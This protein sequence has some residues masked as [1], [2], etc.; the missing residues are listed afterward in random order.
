MGYNTPGNEVVY[1]LGSRSVTF[2][3]LWMLHKFQLVFST[4]LHPVLTLI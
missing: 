2:P 4:E 1:T 3:F